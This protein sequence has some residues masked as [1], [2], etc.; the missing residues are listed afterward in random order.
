MF[1]VVYTPPQTL[2]V[3]RFLG[4]NMVVYIV[5]TKEVFMS[6][7]DTIRSVFYDAKYDLLR[8]PT[9]DL[10]FPDAGDANGL[11]FWETL[12]DKCESLAQRFPSLIEMICTEYNKL[13]K[14]WKERRDTA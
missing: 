2:L 6:E 8:M 13:W 4:V 3:M 10:E 12:R 9:F 7:C 11:R 14:L 5:Y 1:T